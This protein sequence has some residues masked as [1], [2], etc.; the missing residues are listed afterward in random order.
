MKSMSQ[1][2]ILSAAMLPLTSTGKE[3]RR[4]C[5]YWDKATFLAIRGLDV[6]LVMRSM[7]PP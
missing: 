5:P 7:R 2:A 4:I 6:M 1:R 3:P